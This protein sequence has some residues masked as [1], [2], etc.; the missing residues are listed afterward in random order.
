ME[1]DYALRDNVRMLGSILGQVL[2]KQGGPSLLE[3]VEDIR[4]LAKKTRQ[5]N[6]PQA[7]MER[8]SELETDSATS[9][10]RAF[11]QFLALANIA[12]QHHRVR[13]RREYRMQNIPQRGSLSATIPYLLEKGISK[14]QLHKTLSSLSVDLVFTAHP[15]EVNRRTLLQK[16]N[17]SHRSLIS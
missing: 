12:E 8:L 4:A 6:A 10:G 13:R 15:T 5:G 1:K 9:I 11:A 7:L 17:S 3:D 16:Y 14:E 2:S